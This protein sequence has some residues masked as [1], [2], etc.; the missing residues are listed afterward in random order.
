[1]GKYRATRS[2]AL[3]ALLQCISSPVAITPF[4]PHQYDSLIF[5]GSLCCDSTRYVTFPYRGL[6]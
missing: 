3:I 2:C 5:L 1:M 4:C 6:S